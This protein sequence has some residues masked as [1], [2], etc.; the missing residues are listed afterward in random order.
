MNTNNL[1]RYLYGMIIGMLGEYLFRVELNI[2][3][4]IIFVLLIVFAIFDIFY[5]K[6]KQI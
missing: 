2:I 4:L 1:R 5:I 3:P 6:D